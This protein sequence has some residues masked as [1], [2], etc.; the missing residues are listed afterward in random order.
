[1]FP[2]DEAYLTTDLSETERQKII[3]KD[4]DAVERAE[5]FNKQSNNFIAQI[6]YLYFTAKLEINL[7][8]DFYLLNDRELFQQE[9]LYET[10]RKMLV[11]YINK[12]IANSQ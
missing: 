10:E 6:V 12:V 2:A 11:N 1:M 9:G 8:A 5:Y 4:I 7:I 3:N